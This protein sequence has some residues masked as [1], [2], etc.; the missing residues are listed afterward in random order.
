MASLD[1]FVTL[2]RSISLAINA[3]TESN[4]RIHG[5]DTSLGMTASTLCQLGPGRIYNAS[6]IVAGST[7][8][9]VY[10]AN[11]VAAATASNQIA[12]IPMTVGVHIIDMT[13]QYG[14][15]FIPGTGQT[16]SLG[17]S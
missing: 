13:F 8:G 10:D 17:L 6:V 14:L 12:V 11:T 2:V 15:V 5:H 3:Q 4:K 16:V 1:D 9:G 7:V